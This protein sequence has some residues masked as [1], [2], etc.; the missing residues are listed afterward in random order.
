RFFDYDNDGWKDLFV[1]QGHVMDTIEVS[2]PGLKYKEASLLARNTGKGFVDVS[3]ESGA[4]FA[5]KWAARGLAVGDIDN[6]G[7]LDLVV[8]TEGG[9]AYIIRNETPTANHWLIFKLVGRKSNR[10]GI[11]AG[12]YQGGTWPFSGLRSPNLSPTEFD[13]LLT[14]RS[15]KVYKWFVADNARSGDKLALA[16][17]HLKRVQS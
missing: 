10:D 3:S 11:G 17:H 8:T 6:D 5:E 13:S 16:R 1:A 12:G 14:P 4:I 15:K 7:R 9:P 2:S